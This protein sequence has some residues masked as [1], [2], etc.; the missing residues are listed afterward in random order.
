MRR[1][2]ILLVALL[3]ALQLF[4]QEPQVPMSLVFDTTVWDMGRIDEEAGAVSH[5]FHYRNEADH[6]VAIERVYSS[7]G[8]TT[9]DYSRKPLKAGGEGELVVTFDPEGR[10]GRVE[11]SITLVYDGGRGR[12]ELTVKGKVKPRPRAVADEFPYELGGGLRSDASYRAFGNIAQ[13]TTRSMTISLLNNTEEE[14]WPKVVWERQSGA[15]ELFMPERIGAGDRVLVSLTYDLTGQER[16]GLLRDSFRLVATSGPEQEP[17]KGDEVVI[18]CSAIGIDP[19]GE[20]GEPQPRVDIHPTFR[21]FGAIPKG[22]SESVEL[23]I[24]NNGSALLIIR[25][26]ELREGTR[27]DLV[28][29]EVVAPGESLV[30]TMSFTPSMLGRGTIYGG[31]MIVFND[32]HRAVREVRLCAE[33]E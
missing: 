16:Y 9:S 17:R 3:G 15:M 22:Q 24:S 32:P 23:T 25:A 21:D 6:S 29:G 5:T 13:G 28:A 1:V 7:C 12:T 26:V 20:E 8:C 31:A 33:V 11:K 30:R 2:S 14:M 10:Q 4:S 19:M 27:L 18:N